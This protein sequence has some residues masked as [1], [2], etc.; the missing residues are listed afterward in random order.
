LKELLRRREVV[1]LGISRWMIRKL[2][3]QGMLNRVKP[4]ENG[5][6]Y[7]RRAE[8]EKVFETKGTK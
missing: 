2:E 3:Q 4:I 5:H 8:V 6:G 7:Y 1:A